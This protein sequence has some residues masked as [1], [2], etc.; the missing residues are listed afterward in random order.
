MTGSVH[1]T[2]LNV[3]DALSPIVGWLDH[4]LIGIIKGY[5]DVVWQDQTGTG[6]DAQD[7]IFF[8]KPQIH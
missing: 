4:S 3:G 5:D 8:Y 7:R 1:G 2:Q 6:N